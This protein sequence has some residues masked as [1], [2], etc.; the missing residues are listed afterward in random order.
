MTDFI[1]LRERY[2]QNEDEKIKLTC[3]ILQLIELDNK[4]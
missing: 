1:V 3:E 4:T 2:S